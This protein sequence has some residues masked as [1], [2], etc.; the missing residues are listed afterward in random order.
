MSQTGIGTANAKEKKKFKMPH[1]LVIILTIAFIASVLTWIIPAGSFPR[2]ENSLGLKVIQPDKFEYVA[3]KPVNPLLLPNFIINGFIGTADLLFLI[4]LSGC[5]FDVIATSGALHA[6]IAKIAKKFSSRESVFI[7]MLTLVFA[8]ISTTQG[9]NTFI[10]FAPITVMLARAMGF[11]SI[12]GASLI[13]LGGAV[14]FATGTL[15]PSTTIVAQKLAELPLYSGIGYRAFAFVVFLIVTNIYLIRYAKKVRKNPELSPMY[16]L[17]KKEELGDGKDL[18]SFGEMNLRNWLVIISLVVTLGVI[19]YG[20]VKLDWGLN[21]NSIAFIWL[22]I[23]AGLCA[24]FSPSKIASCFVNGA[25]KMI[26]A[27]LIIGMARAIS[28]VLTAGVIIDTIVY[29]LGAV[30]QVIPSAF[31]GVAMY[32]ANTVI[33]IFIV[34]GSGQATAVMPIFIPLADM[35]GLTRQTAVLAFNFGDGFC[36]YVLPMSTA[37]MGTLGVSNIPYDRWMKFMWKL[38]LIWMLV[39]SVLVFIAQMINFGPM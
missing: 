14:G 33:N 3:S 24:G 39:A 1:S 2:V 10:A 6:A 15:N 30:M 21:E 11:D 29:G 34:S 16:D 36:N 27:A 19:V 12:V 26:G 5:A 35:V 38:F 8:L 18:D 9:V 20:G 32:I 31:Q 25:K 4:L 13:L 28:G 17:D 7:P 22:G 37:L 23:V